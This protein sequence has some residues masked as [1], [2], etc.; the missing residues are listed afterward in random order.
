MRAWLRFGRRLRAPVR[1]DLPF[2]ACQ[3]I[4]CLF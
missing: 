1:F 2:N 4:P 3:W